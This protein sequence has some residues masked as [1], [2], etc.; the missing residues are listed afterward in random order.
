MIYICEE[1]GFLFCRMGEIKDCPS[2]EKHH[3]RFADRGEGERLRQYIEGE[4]KK[5]FAKE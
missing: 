1:C 3:I 5:I 4:N 2:C